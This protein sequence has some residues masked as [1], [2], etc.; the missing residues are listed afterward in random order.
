MRILLSFAGTFRKENVLRCASKS[1][2]LRL[3]ETSDNGLS[4]AFGDLIAENL[5][6][7]AKTGCKD[8]FKP[9]TISHTLLLLP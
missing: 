5:T 2:I 8:D 1:M 6:A 3:G 4:E 7:F 9:V